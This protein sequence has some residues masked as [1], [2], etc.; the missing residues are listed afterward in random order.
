MTAPFQTPEARAAA[1]PE[2]IRTAWREALRGAPSGRGA[3]ERLVPTRFVFHP[4]EWPDPETGAS[5][6]MGAYKAACRGL[7]SLG[8]VV[9][10]YSPNHPT[11]AR[12]GCAPLEPWP[13]M[14]IVMRA[15][16]TAIV[17]RA[18]GRPGPMSDCNVVV[19]FRE[20]L[21]RHEFEIFYRGAFGSRPAGV[22][23]RRA[24]ASR[25][26]PPLAGASEA[27]REGESR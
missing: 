25:P 3:G 10:P 21:T 11:A 4:G 20:R 18:D 8:C 24:E 6:P 9:G 26:A 19:D 13:E 5:D 7:Q 16:L 12:R 2:S 1:W 17:R 22:E 23:P 27:E 15:L 14:L